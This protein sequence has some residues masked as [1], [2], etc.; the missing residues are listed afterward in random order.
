MSRVLT[1][2]EELVYAAAFALSFHYKSSPDYAAQCGRAAVQALREARTGH[3]KSRT[4]SEK[5][6]RDFR[7]D[8]EE[9]K[10]DT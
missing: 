7:Q 2:P 9:A 4:A 1:A 10:D 5:M 8:A 6:L 3:F